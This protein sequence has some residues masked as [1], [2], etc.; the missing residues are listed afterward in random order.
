MKKRKRLGIA[1]AA[2]ALLVLLIWTTMGD[3]P[4]RIAGGQISIRGFT[5]AIVAFFAVR[6]LLHAR[7]E[8]AETQ[9]E[10]KDFEV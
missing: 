1:L 4:V 2:Y 6:T 9:D 7:S 5:L 10:H 3:I 8:R